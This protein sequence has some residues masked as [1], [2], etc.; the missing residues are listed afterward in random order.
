MHDARN[1]QQYKRKQQQQQ[2]RNQEMETYPCVIGCIVVCRVWCPSIYSGS[3]STRNLF[4]FFIDFVSRYVVPLNTHID[5]QTIENKKQVGVVSWQLGDALKRVE[6]RV[7]PRIVSKTFAW[8]AWLPREQWAS[9]RQFAIHQQPAHWRWMHGSVFFVLFI[10]V[11]MLI[12][13]LVWL[14]DVHRV[15]L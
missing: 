7:A 11:L 5:H 12:V 2:Q 13:S 8:Y 10:L 14:L 6:E 4:L 9:H 15:L 3:L 1:Q